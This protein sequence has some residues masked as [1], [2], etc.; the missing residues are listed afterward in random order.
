M[1]PFA[2]HFHTSSA[3]AHSTIDVGWNT[4]RDHLGS[5]GEDCLTTPYYP[6]SW[7]LFYVW[8]LESCCQMVGGAVMVILLPVV[9]KTTQPAS[10]V[11]THFEIGDATTGIKSGVYA[12]LLSWS[13][14]QYSLYGYDA[15]AYLTEET[16]SADINGPIAILSSI[17]LV[18]VFGWGVILALTFTIQV[19]GS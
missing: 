5:L 6:L 19:I 13:V 18:S 9:A 12:V 10:Y 14:S 16:K 17:A 7:S 1:K 4:L 15:A 3:F 2:M 8:M 11:F